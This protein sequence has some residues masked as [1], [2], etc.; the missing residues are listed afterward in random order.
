MPRSRSLWVSASV[1]LAGLLLGACSDSLVPTGPEAGTAAEWAAAPEWTTFQG[2][3]THT[4]YVP[5]TTDP[6]LFQ[7]LWTA[8]VAP[9]VKLTPA[10]AGDSALFVST[11]TII[12]SQKTF[13]LETRT[14]QVRWERDFG[15]IRGVHP[16]AYA[17]GRVW[18]TTSGHSDSFLHGLDS[19][20]GTVLAQAPYWN[21]WS[22][23]FAP[24]IVGN[25][26][27]MAGGY[28]GGLYRFDAPDAKEIWFARTNQY[29]EWTPAVRDGRVYT[30]TGSER[31]MVTVHD[32]A[33]GA[34]TDSIADPG[35]VWSGWSMHVA[36]VLGDHSNL[37]TT[38]GGRLLSFDLARRRI[39]YEIPGRFQGSPA[40]EG[41]VL[42]V[43][44]ASAVEA[45]RESDGSLL[46]SWTATDGAAPQHSLV[47][48]KTHVFASTAA[49]ATY[50]IERQ[51]GSAQWSYSAGG[52]LALSKQGVL[53][54][55]GA[56][57]SV[58]AIQLR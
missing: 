45:R 4:G 48:S 5:V 46:W 38:Q 23:Y 43:R 14:G 36:P 41:G 44:N 28:H 16:P 35:F 13:A 39:G 26:I 25:S 34:Q 37:L 50:A 18:V 8:S 11:E 10:T 15:T 52:H 2:N 57:G 31:P 55:A 22:R 17:D 3:A 7:H 24:T 33:T 20:S 49:G 9:G 56:S 54:I 53:V 29:D 19:R 1:L 21:Q 27:F 30:Y 12:G 42:Y 51:S 40:V 58:T 6:A 32:A 47:L